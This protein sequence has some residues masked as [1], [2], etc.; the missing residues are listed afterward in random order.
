M[1]SCPV[2]DIT[3][4][5]NTFCLENEKLQHKFGNVFCYMYSQGIRYDAKRIRFNSKECHSHVIKLYYGVLCV[6]QNS[7]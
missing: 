5:K 4:W 3:V 2:A 1:C 7:S 6:L